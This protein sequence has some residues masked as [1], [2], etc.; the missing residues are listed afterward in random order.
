MELFDALDKEGNFL[1]YDL[2]RG[3]KIP[4]GVY[5]RIV[6]IYTINPEGK[7]LLTLRHPEKTFG[8]MWEITAGSVVKGEDKHRA[9][10]R[11]LY[12]ETGID[13]PLSRIQ[14]LFEHAEDYSIWSSYI[15]FLNHEPTI[16]YQ[17]KETIDHRWVSLQE[18]ESEMVE[19][20]FPR[21]LI[22]RFY[23]QKEFVRKRL[24]EAG[25]VL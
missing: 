8:N 16:R 15:L 18:L 23:Q 10:Q 24:N 17:D 20:S 19:T 1:G 9:A 14:F 22:T 4:K 7:I 5:H 12:E 2:V 3:E 25:F 13:A 21:H 11:E 6:C